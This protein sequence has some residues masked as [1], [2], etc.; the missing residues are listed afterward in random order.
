MIFTIGMIALSTCLFALLC[1][2]VYFDRSRMGGTIHV[3]ESGEKKIFT[4]ELH[5]DPDKMQNGD[6]VVFEVKHKK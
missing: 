3:T 6:M 2:V 5:G 4:L 1:L